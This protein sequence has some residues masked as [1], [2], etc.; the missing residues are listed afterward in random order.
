MHLFCSTGERQEHLDAVISIAG[1]GQR[2]RLFRVLDILTD[3]W[4]TRTS[5]MMILKKEK[6]PTTKIIDDNEKIRSLT[7]A[8]EFTADIPQECVTYDQEEVDLHSDGRIP[9]EIC[10]EKSPS[11]QRRSNCGPHD[12]IAPAWGWLSG[13][14]R[15]PCHFHQF[16]HD[17]WHQELL[18]H[19]CPESKLT[20]HVLE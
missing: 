7:E 2:S 9:P 4:A 5:Q 1:A 17:E 8:Q 14:C 6:D 12:S 11:T 3:K 13:R 19:R 16:I 15:S 20:K 18:S 10:F